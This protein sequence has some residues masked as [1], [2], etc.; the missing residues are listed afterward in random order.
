M[1]WDLGSVREFRS[2]LPRPLRGVVLGNG[3]ETWNCNVEGDVRAE[4]A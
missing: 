4:R 2:T 1:N 3:T